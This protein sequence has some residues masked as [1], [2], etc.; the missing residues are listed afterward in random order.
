MSILSTSSSGV[1][2]RSGTVGRPRLDADATDDA[3]YG[4]FAGV[5]PPYDALDAAREDTGIGIMVHFVFSL[6]LKAHFAIVTSITASSL[7]SRSVWR[8][9]GKS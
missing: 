7:L 2:G 8:C 4:A 6:G 1:S 9:Q 5:P 3:E